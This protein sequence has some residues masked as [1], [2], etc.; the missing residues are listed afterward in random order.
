PYNQSA[1]IA[2]EATISFAGMTFG[3]VI[4]YIFTALL[5]RLVGAEFLGI[6]SIANSLTKLFEVFGKAGL[7]TGILRFVSMQDKD[8]QKDSIRDNIQSAIKM[9]SILSLI[10]MAL[11]LGMAG[12]IVN[13]FYRGN[14]NL[15]FTLFIF[16]F[17]IPFSSF[18]LVAGSAT[19]GF[20]LLKYKVFVAQM[21]VP[22]VLLASMVFCYF[23][24]DE[25]YIIS[26]PI[27]F[28]S[29]IGAIVIFYFLRKI[30]KIR[31]HS[32][33]SAKINP[34]LLKFSIPLLF[35]TI[36]GTLMH[37]T[38]ILMIGYFM[39]EKSVGLYMP[40]V[41]TAGL[42]RSV[43]LAFMS[44][45]S[46]M[47]SELNAKSDYKGM[48]NMYNLVVRWILSL[49]IPI[50]IIFILY[51]TKVMLLFGGQFK[52]GADA[53]V[54][55]TCA[56]LIQSLLGSGGSVLTMTG[57]TKINLVNSILITTLNIVLN[58]VLIPKYGI[59]G[60]AYA[61]L[62][63]FIG[64]G[65]IR[66]VE[67]QVL[68]RIN[69]FSLKLFKPIIAGLGA[70]GAGIFIRPML[71]SYHTIITLLIASIAIFI[72]FYIILWILKFD[73]DDKSILAGL[74]M[75]KRKG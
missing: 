5:A 71:M 18:V 6:Y 49:A 70:C 65:L 17:S 3:Q 52:A 54:I 23:V 74:L 32:I 2:K 62:I 48:V 28:S 8:T 19:Q 7:D 61:T 4:R 26:I 47:I 24:F 14:S 33:F 69:P 68:E 72:P 37:W 39:D 10:L 36:L 34:Q 58:F 43:M 44:I 29:V 59:Y 60:A 56:A 35:M 40:A 45:F 21:L 46:P 73:D 50:S 63:S 27:L 9:S 13:S 30:S 57:H 67:I 64:I 31:L 20:K 53:L 51:S 42:I 11:Q 41:R 12:W 22:F 25:K 1:K 66:T 55:L 16:A 15:T 75:I 38:D